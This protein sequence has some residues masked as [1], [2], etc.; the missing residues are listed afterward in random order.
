MEVGQLGV[1]GLLVVDPVELV[2]R[3]VLDAVH[4]QRLNMAG[5]RAQ[6]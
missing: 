6:V 3:N 5:N 1:V 4:N 2:L